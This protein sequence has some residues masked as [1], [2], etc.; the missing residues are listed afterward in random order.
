MNLSFNFSSF[1]LIL[2]LSV[3]DAMTMVRYP[4]A[5]GGVKL[6]KPGQK[7]YPVQIPLTPVAKGTMDEEALFE[8]LQSGE[9]VHFLTSLIVYW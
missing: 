7:G 9:K 2:W 4:M 1:E 5:W 6:F 8:L 3:L